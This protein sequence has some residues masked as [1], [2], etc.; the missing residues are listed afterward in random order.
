MFLKQRTESRIII[1][2]P[3][4]AITYQQHQQRHFRFFQNSKKSLISF[5][6]ITFN[7]FTIELLSL[8]QLRGVHIVSGYNHLFIE[9][10]LLFPQVIKHLMKK[11]F[12]L[13][14]SRDRKSMSVFCSPAK[15]SKAVGNK[16]FIKV[17]RQP[18]PSGLPRS[19]L[20][21]S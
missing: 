13:E 12:T 17:R 19:V 5:K 9:P 20:V 15:S 2:D 21:T 4:L 7:H 3:S 8:A 18:P 1:L 11:E 16:M 10:S 6:K 14:F